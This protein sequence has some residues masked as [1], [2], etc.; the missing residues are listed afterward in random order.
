MV[1]GSSGEERSRMPLLKAK[2]RLA[3]STTTTS[4]MYGPTETV[5]PLITAN[6]S[7]R[8][9]NFLKVSPGRIMPTVNQIGVHPFNTRKETLQI[10]L[11][12]WHHRTNVC[13]FSASTPY[14]AS[15]HHGIGGE[16]VLYITPTTHPPVAS[17]LLWA[18]AEV[19]TKER[20]TENGK[21]NH[22]EISDE[23]VKETGLFRP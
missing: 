21:I 16:A 4:S 19:L 18:L 10:L 14:E 20:V 17:T 23:D 8:S 9:R 1:V 15:N 3:V 11:A 6:V 12:T 2:S 7:Q 5:A 22:F 13:A